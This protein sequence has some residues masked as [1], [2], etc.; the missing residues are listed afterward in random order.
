MSHIPFVYDIDRTKMSELA[1]SIPSCIL[2]REAYIKQQR[3]TCTDTEI[4]WRSTC[5]FGEGLCEGVMRE[6]FCV[7]GMKSQHTSAWTQ[8]QAQIGMGSDGMLANL[9]R[10]EWDKVERCVF[11]PSNKTETGHT[12]KN[13]ANR[14]R[15]HTARRD[16]SS[17]AAA[18]GPTGKTCC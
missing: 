5:E 6:A 14:D 12:W 17:A 9:R 2:E 11:R 3:K 16:A 10:R 18:A 15:Y 7:L 4:T 8:R 1:E 13:K